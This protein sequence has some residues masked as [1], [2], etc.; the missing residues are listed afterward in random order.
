M[1]IDFN[2]KEN[3]K[4]SPNKIIIVVVVLAVLF[5]CFFFF[6]N[7]GFGSEEVVSQGQMFQPIS[8]DF[9][10]ISSEEFQQLE[11]FRGIPVLPGFFDASDTKTEAEKIASGR[12]NPFKEVSFEEIELAVVKVIQKLMTFEEIEEMR[13]T[14]ENS[15]LYTEKEKNSLHVK[16]NE[17]EEMIKRMLE[18][19]EEESKGNK[20]IPSEESDEIRNQDELISP[21]EKEESND[22]LENQETDYYKEW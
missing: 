21:D 1:A 9:D 17:Q 3:S 4:T 20:T 16:L 10:F 14:I 11:N 5:V 19:D 13:S 18:P 6:K 2:N 15:L 12:N 8:I 7:G 22:P